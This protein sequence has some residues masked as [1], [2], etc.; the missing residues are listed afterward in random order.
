[1]LI[2]RTMLLTSHTIIKNR[3][4]KHSNTIFRK[5]SS[6]LLSNLNLVVFPRE[7][8]QLNYTINFIPLFRFISYASF[9][10]LF[11]INILVGRITIIVKFSPIQKQKS[12]FG[13]N[14]LLVQMNCLSSTL[15]IFSFFFKTQGIFFSSRSSLFFCLTQRPKNIFQIKVLSYLILPLLIHAISSKRYRKGS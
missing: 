12:V 2:Q 10:V 14:I 13:W 5:L 3:F 7:K 9:V 4:I 1:M 11:S 8:I 6:Y 15:F